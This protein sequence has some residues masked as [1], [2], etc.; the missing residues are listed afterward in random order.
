VTKADRYIQLVHHSSGRTRFR[1]AWISADREGARNIAQQLVERA[2]MNEVRIRPR[3]G[4]VL[5]LHER[6]LGPGEIL[7]E[8]R[9]ITGVDTVHGPGERP[10]R[11]HVARHGSTL[12]HEMLGLFRE[13]DRDLLRE[14]EGHL[15]LSSLA[16][17]GFGAL[18]VA[19]TIRT[20]ELPVPPWYSLAWWSFRVLAAVEAGNLEKRGKGTTDGARTPE[21]VGPSGKPSAR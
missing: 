15:N 8:L 21:P 14:T 7:D 10:P 12:G 13:V 11:V 2:G 3:T 17:L 9:R 4:S 19:N 6:T 1:L 5:C 18:G 20:G 16:V